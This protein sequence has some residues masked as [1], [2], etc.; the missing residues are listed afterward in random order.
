MLI[1]KEGIPYIGVSTFFSY[2][3][4]RTRLGYIGWVPA[5]FTTY[6]FRDPERHIPDGDRL[7]IS[8]A[9]GK[10]LN[11]SETNEER[12]GPC[13]KVSIFMSIFNVHVNRAMVDGEVVGKHY[14]PGE[15]HLA[16][17]GKKT[18]ANERMILY[19]EN[20]AGIF[21]VDQVAGLVARRIVCWPEIGDRL[22]S[23]QRIGL[24]HFG[25]LLECYIP[26]GAVI[27]VRK[28]DR[29]RAGQSLLG[30]Y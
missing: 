28:G 26:S 13:S 14:R 30:R 1:R 8:P 27:S 6:F 16:F 10:V 5:L 18:D 19:V 11:I 23:G 17:V 25:S 22:Y 9:D 12:V 3:I 20:D 4:S 21:R 24:I 29:V 15:F 7:I 2:L